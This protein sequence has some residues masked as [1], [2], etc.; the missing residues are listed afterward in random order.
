MAVAPKKWDLEVDLVVLGS[1]GGGLTEAIVD[2]DAGLKTVVLEKLDKLGGGHALS[3]GVIWIPLNDHQK[4]DGYKDSKEAA[5]QWIRDGS[6]GLHDEAKAEAYIDAGPEAMR[7]LEQYPPLRLCVALPSS[8]YY[9]H[10]P[11]FNWGRVISSDPKIMPPLLEELEKKQPLLGKV[12]PNRNGAVWKFELGSNG[13]R[14]IMGALVSACVDRNL[15]ILMETGAEELVVEDGRVT[16]VRAKRDGKDYY[17]KGERAVLI[18]TGGFEHNAEM[19]K[20]YLPAPGP[21]YA[22]TPSG[23]TGDGQLMGMEVGAAT[24][25]M[26]FG[27]LMS[28]VLDFDGKPAP[29]AVTAIPGL[30]V[31]NRHGKRCCNETLYM[32]VGRAL[33]NIATNKDPRWDNNPMYVLMDSKAAGGR[34]MNFARS[35]NSIKE[36]AP[37]IGLNPEVLDETVKR[38]N[39]YAALGQDPDFGRGQYQ[40]YEPNFF[41]DTPEKMGPLDIGPYYA[42]PLGIST[43]GTKGGLVT[44]VHAQVLNV[45]G[46]VIPGLY[47]TSNAAAHTPFGGGYTSGQSNGNSMVFGYVAAKHVVHAR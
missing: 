37:K 40:K 10:I 29:A 15:P 45:R 42:A 20:R 4:Q 22:N 34:P 25:L 32:S 46:K 18:A 12:Q 41:P 16:G 13:G 35:A 26:S 38:Y 3:G 19:N 31:V 5:L 28:M 27:I 21:I 14:C 43:V 11:T 9:R 2:H 1:S 36:L 8:D 23:N 24:A 47:A 33:M 30:I 17:I 44:N 7:Y 6:L 39:H